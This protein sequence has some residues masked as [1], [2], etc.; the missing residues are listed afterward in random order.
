[1]FRHCHVI[2]K[3]AWRM[4]IITPQVHMLTASTLRQSFPVSLSLQKS[5]ALSLSL[6]LSPLSPSYVRF[7][8]AIHREFVQHHDHHGDKA[9]GSWRKLLG[10]NWFITDPLW[11]SLIDLL[12]PGDARCIPVKSRLSVSHVLLHH[13]SWISPWILPCGPHSAYGCGYSS[14]P[15]HEVLWCMA[16]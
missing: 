2:V 5:G 14:R 9:E 12:Y 11:R 10:R 4:K 6:S 7:N 8:A 3:N 13:F 16:G 1:M 15:I